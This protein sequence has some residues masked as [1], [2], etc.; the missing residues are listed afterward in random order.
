MIREEAQEEQ[1]ELPGIIPAIVRWDNPETVRLRKYL[2]GTHVLLEHVGVET[3]RTPHEVVWEKDK[4]K[5]RL[6]RYGAGEAKRHRIPLL[7]VYAL[8]LRPYILDLVPGRSLVEH[9]ARAGFDVYLLDFGIPGDE[10]RYLSLESYVLGYLDEVVRA[11]PRRGDPGKLPW[12]CS[13][14]VAGRDKAA[15]SQLSSSRRPPRRHPRRRRP[16]PIHPGLAGRVQVG[17]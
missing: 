3:G 1:V 5:V 2:T 8:V 4:V 7:L 14:L 11:G 16:G 6:Y 12:R 17:G 15:P 9:L 10:D 13:L